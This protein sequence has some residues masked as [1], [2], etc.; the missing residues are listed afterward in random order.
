V[1]SFDARADGTPAEHWSGDPRLVRLPD[2]PLENIDRLV[3]VA[4]HPDDETLGAGGLLASC[5]ARGIPVDVV[6]VTDGAASHPAST[7]H[8]PLELTQLR[9]AEFLRA[10]ACVAPDAATYFLGFPDGRILEL[11]DDVR[12]R[13]AAVMVDATDRT[14]IVAPWRGDGHRDHRVLGEIC[15]ALADEFTSRFAEYPIWMWHWGSPEHPAVPWELL[16][17]HRLDER[18]ASAKRRAIAAYRSQIEPLST[19]PGDEPVLNDGFLRHFERDFEV[20]FVRGDRDRTTLRGDYFD[21]KYDHAADPWGFE[22]RWY[23]SRKRAV[24]VAALPAERY[25]SV[26]EIGCSIGVLTAEL[27]PR[28]DRL[29]SVD[30]SQAAIDRATQRLAGAPHVTLER[31]DVGTHFPAGEYDL[32]VLSEVGYYFDRAGLATLLDA[33]EGSLSPN[34][35]LLACHW[36]HPVDDYPQTGDGVHEAIRDRGGLARVV[37]HLEKDFRL[38]VFSRDPRS[39]A[40]RS[41]LA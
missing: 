31:R 33:I 2:L 7:T 14:L 6:V 20:F 30:V 37:S 35:T 39:V 10:I 18:A 5:C 28:S 32:I 8:S 25:G 26:L 13:L 16:H 4:A 41:G 3:V 9:G 40:E 36:R 15:A 27:A 29:L 22:T 1:V 17:A 12:V 19:E 23:E 11:R 21:E 24:T 34:G 38:E